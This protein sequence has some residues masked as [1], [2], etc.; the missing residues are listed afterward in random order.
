MLPPGPR[1]SG[2][3]LASSVEV[4]RT[5]GSGRV[6]AEWSVY[7]LDMARSLAEFDGFL[8]V[9]LACRRE[10]TLPTVGALSKESVRRP[11]VGF[12]I[13]DVR[14]QEPCWWR[15]QRF[16]WRVRADARDFTG[17]ALLDYPTLDLRPALE[18][19]YFTVKAT[20]RPLFMHVRHASGG[21]ARAYLRLLVPARRAG[22]DTVGAIASIIR[23]TQHAL[24][25]HLPA[26]KDERIVELLLRAT[27]PVPTAKRATRLLLSR[28]GSIDAIVQV[29]VDEICAVA[30]LSRSQVE[31]L[32]ALM[33][34]L[35]ARTANDGGPRG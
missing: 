12:H 22:S 21:M 35:K 19:D 7:P 17:T 4:R 25:P 20:A 15:F 10:R 1:V 14:A 18:T 3:L 31:P 30:G 24:F 27:V 13:V 28:F 23:P 34:L 32:Q 33:D 26:A 11:D 29:P 5:P 8:S 9:W 2:A 16:D 6:P